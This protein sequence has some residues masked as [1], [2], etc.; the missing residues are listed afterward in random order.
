MDIE[1]A[2]SSVT[3]PLTRRETL[4]SPQ[5]QPT[6]G[7]LFN[8]LYVLCFRTQNLSLQLN[9]ILPTSFLYV[10]FQASGVI[11]AL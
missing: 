5:D 4:M 7:A 10:L 2:Q 8:E 1:Y 6:F 11:Y 9:N 3:A